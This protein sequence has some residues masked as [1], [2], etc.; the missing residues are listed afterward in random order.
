MHYL[1]ALSIWEVLELQLQ[2]TLKTRYLLNQKV[3]VMF[4]EFYNTLT[5]NSV[6]LNISVLLGIIIFAKGVT[7]LFTLYADTHFLEVACNLAL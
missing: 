2:I 1:Q 7:V 3:S 4:A 6:R 5:S